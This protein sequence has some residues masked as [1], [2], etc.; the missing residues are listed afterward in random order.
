MFKDFLST[1]P[2]VLSPLGIFAFSM[3]CCTGLLAVSAAQCSKYDPE[4][5]KWVVHAF[6]GIFS[7]F[8][9]TVIYCPFRT[10]TVTERLKMQ[11]GDIKN[12]DKPWIVL[13][14]LGSGLLAYMC[15]QGVRNYQEG[16][17][18]TKVAV[19]ASEQGA[20]Q[21]TGYSSVSASR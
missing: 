8:I 11:E 1:I 21:Q 10:A 13:A 16:L 3:V 9:L 20:A 2:K 19:H 6:L 14:A 4:A 12:T 15:Y 18:Q 17:R 7:S 5:F